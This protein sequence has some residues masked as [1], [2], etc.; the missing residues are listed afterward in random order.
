M[1]T[2]QVDSH[3]E[4]DRSVISD[5]ALLS[6]DIETNPADGDRIFKIGVVRSDDRRAMTFSPQRSTLPAVVETLNA[7]AMGAEYLVG[8]NLRRH[9]IPCL[10]A[11]MPG[12][13]WLDLPVVDTLELSALAFPANPYHRLVKGYKLVSD[14]R[15][16]PERDAQVALQLLREELI[17]L[18]EMNASDPKWGALLHYLMAPNAPLCRLFDRMRLAQ[19][20]DGKAATAIAL[21]R[22][23]GLC[24]EMNL[25]RLTDFEHRQSPI[26]R[27]TLAYALGWIR[28]SG[29]NS[30]LPSW[31]HHT[32]PAARRAITELRELNCGHASCVY[33]KQQHNPEAL[34]QAYFQKPT[35]RQ[36]PAA[37]DGSS[38][39]RSIVVAGL[40]RESLLAILP[41]GGGKSI[42]YQLP[43]LTHY[44]R[45]GQ[46]TVIVSPLQSLMKDQVDNLLAA[47][48]TCAVTI[49]GLLTPVERRA[50]LDKIRLGDAGIVLV[51][52]E[53]FR[54]RTFTEAIRLREIAAWVFDEAHCLSKWGHDFRTDYLYV[55]RYIRENF[56]DRPVPIACFTATA[57]PDVIEDL[58]D[59]FKESLGIELKRFLGGHERTNLSY[60]V[61]SAPKEQ[62]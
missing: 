43:A 48:V 50:A 45:A 49:N 33:C 16:D 4:L 23:Q 20:P 35:F 1:T 17:A 10:A 51:S 44:W 32:M 31:V 59:H 39:Q 47:G 37:P 8:H 18:T 15:N 38:L 5:L 6:V 9:D 41:T 28:V 54:S 62:R 55:S 46:L 40:Q 29:G 36:M 3:S 34:L 60:M 30:V 19:A 27:E 7:F 42:C 14:S 25:Q 57:K 26:E 13:S 24:C 61:I 2:I 12:L 53:Q 56:S 21:D 58:T 11:Q 52:P 22:F